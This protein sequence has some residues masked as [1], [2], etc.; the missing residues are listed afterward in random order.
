MP[1]MFRYEP[2]TSESFE[3]TL[4]V[5]AFP[6]PGF[7]SQVAARHIIASQALPQ[8]GAFRCDEM[9][10]TVSIEAGV[11]Q[12]PMRLY[13]GAQACGL[14]QECVG[15][16]VL[17]GDVAPPEHLQVA[18]ARTVLDWARDS[19][20]DVIATLE[21]MPLAAAGAQGPRVSGAS[22]RADCRDRLVK[23][24][25][26]MLDGVLVSGTTAAFFAEAQ[27]HDPCVLGLFAE[28]HNQFQ[29]A[30]GAAKLV[31]AVDKLLVNIPIDVE[32]LRK[33]AEELTRQL[34][35]AADRSR[36]APTLTSI[37]MYG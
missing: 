25:I 15:L 21:G 27:P 17:L 36:V 37:P 12:A 35:A 23:E 19:G 3:G 14:D 10:P 28:A 4:L 31:E 2:L 29:D 26:A 33:R 1:P 34:Q 7:V 32:P 16:G 9:P 5:V 22:T 11:P 13:L 6:S 24:G 20:V 8:V 30:A 18:F